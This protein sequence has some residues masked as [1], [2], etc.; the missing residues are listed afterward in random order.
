MADVGG[1]VEHR[2]VP[3]DGGEVLGEGLEVPRDAGGERRRVHVLDLLQRVGDELA[4][5]GP[6]RGDGE[7]AVAGDDGGDAVEAR[8]GERRVP[9][10]LGVVVGVDVDEAGGHDAAVGVDGRV[11]IEVGADL[12]D[13]V[14]R[15]SATSARTPG[16]PVPSTT[17]P[18]R[19]TVLAFTGRWSCTGSPGCNVEGP[20]W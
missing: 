9:E 11:A 18:P 4:V 5:L 3:L 8:R 1:E 17:V 12:D 10:H 14:A 2:A 16:A 20:A 15:R 7:P 6:G 19:M 13:P